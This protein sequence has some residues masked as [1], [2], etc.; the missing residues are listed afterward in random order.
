MVMK[1]NVAT[2]RNNETWRN[3][4][5][6]TKTEAKQKKNK[7]KPMKKGVA[8]LMKMEKRSRIEM[9]ISKNEMKNLKMAN[10]ET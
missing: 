10:I 7:M 6:K 5:M 2:K 3:E 9:K 4:N 1:K 8:K